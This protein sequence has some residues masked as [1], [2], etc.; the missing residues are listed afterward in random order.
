MDRAAYV[1]ALCSEKQEKHSILSRCSTI[2]IAVTTHRTIITFKAVLKPRRVCCKV[3]CVDESIVKIFR[4]ISQ[5][6]RT[7]LPPT[8]ELEEALCQIWGDLLVIEQVG[9]HD[10]FFEIGGHSLLGTR[11]LSRV[12]E[13][14]G[15]ELGLWQLYECSTVQSMATAIEE[16]AL[17]QLESEI[18]D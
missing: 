3:C 12:Q 2:K 8:N 14:L 18:K 6:T 4:E 16:Q 1:E 11:I 7:F 17:V 9:I 13:I 15:I 10:D 5:K